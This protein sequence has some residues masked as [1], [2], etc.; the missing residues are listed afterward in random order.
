M[1]AGLAAI[2]LAFGCGQE[3]ATA[4]TGQQQVPREPNSIIREVATGC[5]PEVITDSTEEIETVLVTF[6]VPLGSPDDCFPKLARYGID[7]ADPVAVD[8]P[9]GN[10]AFEVE[11][12]SRVA[13]NMPSPPYAGRNA[14]CTPCQV[15]IEFDPPVRKL[16][17]SYSRRQGEAA[18][19][20]AWVAA[21]SILVQATSRK[22]GTLSYEQWDWKVLYSNV[23]HQ[24]LP[25][26]TWSPTQLSSREWGDTIQWVWFNG[27]I[28]I[29]DLKITRK[30]LDCKATDLRSSVSVVRGSQVKCTFKATPNWTV[31][32]WEFIPD[33]SGLP[34]IQENSSSR[35]WTGTAATSGLV[36][37]HVTDG[38]TPRTWQSRLSVLDRPSHWRFNWNYQQGT[39]QPLPDEEFV[40]EPSGVF[41]YGL[42]CPQQFPNKTDCLSAE[43]SFVQPDP[44]YQPGAG[45]VAFLIPTGPNQTYWLATSLSYNM[46]RIANVH[47]G[48]LL[49]Q[50]RKHPVSGTMLTREC[51]RGL[52]LKSTATSGMANTYQANLY[53]GE[54]GFLG[55]DM[56][57]LIPAVWGHEGYG[58][59]G[60]TGHMGV[61][62]SVAVIPENDP[63]KVLDKVVTTDR[64]TLDAFI[65]PR[66]R[67]IA[68]RI[69]G[70]TADSNTVTGPHGNYSVPIDRR[71]QYVWEFAP[72]L[73][74]QVWR[75]YPLSS[76]TR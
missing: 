47:P 15:V 74:I 68:T 62:E 31:T 30:P 36:K 29:D 73:G 37:V 50:A 64:I 76:F 48:L 35:E 70:A 57:R 75:S 53:C 71:N 49:T 8:T 12:E 32:S 39:T 24:G 17:F 46:K 20:N 2:L 63:W 44:R 42:N 58:Y 1:A 18:L 41:T 9:Q 69:D 6:N 5:V 33:V 4:P 34:P 28:M 14:F 10:S 13:I 11:G 26:D 27:S 38:T 19:W 45:Y 65:D 22:P 67:G 54:P 72:S 7:M 66:I 16:E 61:A 3:S 23:A 43:W 25:Y 52:G 59:N 51:K 40:L 56:D 55:L 60:G 21:D